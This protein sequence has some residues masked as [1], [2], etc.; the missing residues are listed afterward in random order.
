M[1]CARA[2][3]SICAICNEFNRDMSYGRAICAICSELNGGVKLCYMY[4]LF[5][6]FVRLVM[7]SIEISYGRATC[8]ICAICSGLNRDNIWMS[9]LR[10]LCVL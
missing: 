8:A 9:Y 10:D 4:V 5:A 7:C 1:L 2:T 6:R 3:C